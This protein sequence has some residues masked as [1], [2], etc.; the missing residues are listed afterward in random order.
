M[1]ARRSLFGFCRRVGWSWSGGICVS[2]SLALAAPVHPG[3]SVAAPSRGSIVADALP[4]AAPAPGDLLPSGDAQRHAD[5]LAAYARGVVAED[6]AESEAA[7]ES[8]RKSFDLDPGNAELAIKLAFLYVQRND[9]S[10]GIGL[11]KDAIKASPRAPTPLIYLS[12]LY[13]KH[14]R[15][16]EQ[17]LKYA[18]QALA[19]DPAF[20]PGYLAVYELQ[21]AAGQTA[22]A[23]ET[24]GAGARAG[25]TDPQ[26]W[27][28]LGG[29]YIRQYLR[30]GEAPG[31]KLA[32]INA[33]FRKAAELGGSDALVLA[34]VGNFFIESRQTKEAIPFYLS[35]L[36]LRQDSDD[37]ILVNA[38]EKLAGALN[39]A[40]QRDEAIEVLERITKDHP[41][42]FET[43]ELLGQLYEA[44]EDFAHALDR[45]QQSLVLEPGEPR[46]HIRVAY[47]Q[48]RLKRYA[49]AIETAR[50]ARARFSDD[51]QPLYLLAIALAE[52]KK[53]NEALSAY[54]QALSEFQDGHEEFLN[55]QF[56]YSYGAAAEQAGLIDKAA[57]LIKKSIELAPES[58]AEAYNFLGYMWVE[59]GENLEE[60]GEMIKKAVASDPE[61]GAYLDSL[62]W[63]F[64][65]KADY[66]KALEQLLKAAVAIKPEDAVVLEHVGDTYQQLGKVPQA[67]QFW[68]KALAVDATSK[69]VAEKIE[70]AK[71]KVSSNK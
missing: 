45:Y 20:F 11:L 54:A 60:A 7:L 8:Y 36:R 48:L 38:A 51:P 10:T 46:H 1:K 13:A 63:Y 17:A 16:P 27:L 5:A 2:A 52:A 15:K 28:D 21:S 35:A 24:L 23:E 40:G 14:L 22:K 9:P 57:E 69:G 3:H 25:S 55:A 33:L 41:S 43:Y 71:Q 66:P 6:N 70:A 12:Q 58:S 67:L 50:A 32:P 30:E 49:E 56:Y 44:K 37:P 18:D 31:D 53:T 4:T 61:N 68:Q 59:H 64:F 65:K 34:K 62:G 19:L 29:L 47:M 42:R 26:F 39:E